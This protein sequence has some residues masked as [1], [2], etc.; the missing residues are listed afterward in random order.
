MGR[1]FP[2]VGWLSSHRRAWLGRDA[3]SG[4]IIMCLLVPRGWRTRRSRGYRQRRLSTS[5]RRR[6][7]RADSPDAVRGQR[8][9]ARDVGCALVFLI[10]AFL[11]LLLLPSPWNLI[12]FAVCIPLFLGELAFWN[13]TVRHRRVQSGAETLIGKTGTVVSTCRPDGQVRLGGEIWEARCEGGADQ[14]ETVAIVS[15]D[16]LTL[17]VE[18]LNTT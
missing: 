12:I 3:V 9:D 5:H 1:V 10:A 6:A 16:D 15:R 18:R 7:E 13:R 14:G 8:L 4:V 2:I 17:V 11:F